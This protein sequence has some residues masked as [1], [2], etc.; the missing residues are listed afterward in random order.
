MWETESSKLR[1]TPKRAPLTHLP[2]I[3]LL[4]ALTESVLFLP[5]RKRRL[6]HTMPLPSLSFSLQSGLLSP[7]FCHVTYLA[8]SK[9]VTCLRAM[10]GAFLQ[11]AWRS[12]DSFHTPV[13]LQTS[14]SKTGLLVPLPACCNAWDVPLGGS[15]SEHS[16][17]RR[18]GLG[19]GWAGGL[20]FPAKTGLWEQA[21]QR[22]TRAVLGKS[23][24]RYYG[25][26]GQRSAYC[27]CAQSLL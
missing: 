26:K 8:S 10:Q 19:Q 20:S 4:L 12:L 5:F 14:A 7:R 2:V 1:P 22:E 25:N 16:P 11:L 23:S 17:A 9:P 6:R 27:V 21:E 18:R 13:P 15:V 3:L 24:I